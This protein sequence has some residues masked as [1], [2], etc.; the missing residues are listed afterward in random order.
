[1]SRKSPSA[2]Q[3][4]RTQTLRQPHAALFAA[5]GDETRLTLVTRLVSGQP[6]SIAQLTAGSR[7]TRQAVTKHLRV[8]QSAGIVRSIRAG[9]ENR[10]ALNPRSLHAM[11]N[12]LD[13]VSS[14]WDH[15]LARLKSFVED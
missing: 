4:S 6:A 10:F 7:I 12:Y 9:R 3:N 8:L 11:Q 1:M 15:A 13:R 2:R 14:Q 5:L